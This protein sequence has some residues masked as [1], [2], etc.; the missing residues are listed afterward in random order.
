MWGF[1]FGLLFYYLCDLELLTLESVPQGPHPLNGDNSTF[2]S[3]VFIN[4]IIENIL[5]FHVLTLLG[6]SDQKER[7]II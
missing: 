4:H 7:V 6:G 3:I 2:A 5:L 1:K